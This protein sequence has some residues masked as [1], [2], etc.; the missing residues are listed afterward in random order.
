VHNSIAS[1]GILCYPKD[2]EY[3]SNLG[4]SEGAHAGS[5]PFGAR[6]GSIR[7]I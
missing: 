3:I 5:K 6:I 7:G 1:L 4:A 2:N